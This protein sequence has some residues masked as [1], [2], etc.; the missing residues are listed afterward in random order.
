MR[1]IAAF[2]TLLLVCG[3]S[4]LNAQEA[5]IEEPSPLDKQFMAQQRALIDD[6]ARRS[7]GSSLSGERD[8]DLALLQT[9]LQRQIVKGEQK[10]ELQAMGVVMGDHLAQEFGLHWVIYT[11]PRGRSRALRYQDSDTYLFPMTMISRRREVGNTE[12][13]TDIYNRAAAIINNVAPPLPYQ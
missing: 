13:V 8:R 3:S 5:R 6:I 7:L 2:I 1:T 11:D 4:V 9:L 10:R 12:T